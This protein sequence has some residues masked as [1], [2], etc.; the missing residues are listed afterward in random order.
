MTQGGHPMGHRW[1]H[2]DALLLSAL[3]W[4]AILRLV[5]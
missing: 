5:F 4:L 2:F 3:I 1:T